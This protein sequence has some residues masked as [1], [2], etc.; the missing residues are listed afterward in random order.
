M[1]A[2]PREFTIIGAGPAGL[3]AAYELM[4]R[5]CDCQILEQARQAGGLSRTVNYRGYRCDIGGHRFFTKNPEVDRLWHEILSED[6]LRRPRL[7]RIYYRGK[8]FNYPLRALNAL[9]GLGLLTSL[10]A[11]ASFLYRRLFPH[12]P[13]ETFADWISN[14]FG[15]TLFRIFF[16]S[17]TE[18]IW[19]IKCTELSA[20][21][22]A[23]RIRNLDLGRALLG[24]V[25]FKPE[26]KVAS[27]IEEFD[28]PRYGPGQMYEAMAGRI[29]QAGGNIQYDSKVT[30]IT[31]QD[32]YITG[33]VIQ[34]GEKRESLP[35]TN[36]IS[37]LPLTELITSMDPP[38][39]PKVLT[40]ARGLRYRSI[41]TVN[42]IINQAE[43][44]PDT[45]LYLHDPEILANRLQLYK[46]WSPAMVPDSQ[47]SV[48]GFEYFVWEGDEFWNLDDAALLLFARED[49][50]KLKLV[51]SQKITD[52][53][54]VRYAKAYP[55]YDEGY[56]EKL[57]CIREYLHGFSNLAC[58]GRYG[59]F[60]YNN[61]DHSIMTGLLAARQLLGEPV[62]PWSVNAEAEYHETG[63]RS[64]S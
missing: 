33:V 11:L 50:E 35:T 22:A 52:G 39:P 14:R 13:E 54:I 40:A 6:F 23:Q 21:W 34:R 28:Y 25:G 4:R 17:Y 27:L 29:L 24:V 42:L 47:T 58:A 8:F 51:E 41:L 10:R 1:Q 20:D 56:R 26:G 19:G 36:L 48:V 7:S 60:R 15:D 49:A 63:G 32:N 31:H 46:N 3:A 61:M 45:W 55:V 9:T 16:K 64:S 59:Q 37:S 44:L 5:A 18:K 43:L 53:F 30:G 57:A 2:D 38:P 62:D 12:R